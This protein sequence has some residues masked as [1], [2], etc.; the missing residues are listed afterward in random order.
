MKKNNLKY[1]LA[2][3]LT[4]CTLFQSC[5]DILDKE[6][7]SRLTDKDLGG[8]GVGFTTAD[9]A[10]AF[11][12]GC[13][14]EFRSEYFQLDYYLNGDAQADNAYAG[15]DNPNIFQ[16]DDYEIE[17]VNA[18]VARDW[19]YLYSAIAKCN[20]VIS[21]IAEVADP[22]LTE[23]RRQEI[24]GE[25][26]FIRAFMYF[27][28]VKQFGA[29]PLMLTEI[30]KI[31]VNDLGSVYVERTP[32]ADIYAQIISDL[33]TALS[34]VATT[35]ANKNVVTKGVVNALFAKVYAT[36]EPHDWTKVNQYCDAVIANGYDLLPEFEQLWDGSQENSSEAIFEIT[37]DGW[38][39]G[40]GN[41]GASMFLGVDWKKFNTPTNDIVRAFDAEGDIIRKTA[42]IQFADVTGKWSDRYWPLTSYPHVNK[43]RNTSGTQNFIIFRLAD[44]MLLKAEALNELSDVNGAATLVNEIRARVDLAP[45]TADTKE[46]MR[47]AIEKE[48]RLELAFEGQR[49]FDLKR[50]GR[51]IEVVNALKDGNGNSLGYQLTS[52][53]LQWPIPQAERDK[54]DKL[55]QNFGY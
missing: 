13:Y 39:A 32:E 43:F 42:S 7:L 14:G 16:I 41:W 55:V 34:D 1:I 18:N 25:A 17:A 5:E 46:E 53:R 47:L 44:I 4:V 52:E 36:L 19:R 40:T 6:P 24:R 9:Q 54:N 37:Y 3:G 12:A 27:E 15:A 50:T 20:T 33:Q 45:T 51:A 48:R 35:S 30:S 21:N 38:D 10:E 31:D 11:L 2:A 22:A 23:Q 49:W 29:A 8:S 28:I 26:S